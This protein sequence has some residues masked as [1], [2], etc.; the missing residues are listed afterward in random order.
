[1][2]RAMVLL[3]ALMAGCATTRGDAPPLVTWKTSGNYKSVAICTFAAMEKNGQRP[4]FMDYE[5]RAKVWTV[6]SSIFGDEVLSQLELIF[7]QRGD[8]VDVEYWQYGRSAGAE[9]R[10]AAPIRKFVEGCASA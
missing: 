1:M 8:Q 2:I 10:D 5:G 4:R 7:I 3:V 6:V 9:P